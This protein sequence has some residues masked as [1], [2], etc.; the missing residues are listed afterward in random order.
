MNKQEIKDYLLAELQRH[1][2]QM[3]LLDKLTAAVSKCRHHKEPNKKIVTSFKEA[4]GDTYSCYWNPGKEEKFDFRQISAWGGP[5]KYEN[6]IYISHSVKE[7]SWDKVFQDLRRY[8]EG[9]KKTI[10]ELERDIANIDAIF[11]WDDITRKAIAALLEEKPKMSY[12]ANRCF[13]DIKVEPNP[14]NPR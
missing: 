14:N 2:D 8:D 1:R 12:A 3:E 13:G 4:N 9:Y 10:S 7:W 11:E 6:R 5:V